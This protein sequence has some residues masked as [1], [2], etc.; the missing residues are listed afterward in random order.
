MLGFF[1]ELISAETTIF[2]QLINCKFLAAIYKHW[3][4]EVFG[5]PF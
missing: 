1:L 3:F 4:K 2:K 5:L